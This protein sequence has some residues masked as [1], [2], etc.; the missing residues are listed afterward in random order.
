MKR[1]ILALAIL[2]VAS[3]AEAQY[4]YSYGGITSQRIG[5]QTFYTGTGSLQGITGSSM[6]IGRQTF[7]NGYNYNN[8]ASLYGNSQTFGNQ[9]FSNFGYTPPAYY[10]NPYSSGYIMGGGRIQAVP[11][12]GIVSMPWGW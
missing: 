10:G 8:G 2:C 12:G 6:Q 9:T 7:Y 11:R 3:V 1:L 4:P 5:N